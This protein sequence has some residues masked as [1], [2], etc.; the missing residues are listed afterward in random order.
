APP[1]LLSLHRCCA[2]PHLNSFP[3]RRSS[4]LDGHRVDLLAQEPLYVVVEL[5]ELRPL[6]PQHGERV[7]VIEEEVPEEELAEEGPPRPLLRSEEHTSELQSRFDLV[8]RLLLEKKKER[9]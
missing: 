3:T 9:E 4:D 7:D 1:R 6:P 5:L 8:C 2:S